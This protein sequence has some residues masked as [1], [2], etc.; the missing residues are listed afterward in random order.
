MLPATAKELERRTFPIGRMTMAEKLL[1]FSSDKPSVTP[2]EIVESALDLVLVNDV[3][4]PLAIDQFRKIGVGRVYDPSRIALV[5][6][7]Y[8]P[9]KDIKSAEQCKALRNFAREL[10]IDN[11]WEI[12]RCGIE[13]VLLPES[14]LVQ[15]GMVIVGADSHTCTYG[16][17]GAFATGIGSTEAADAMATAVAPFMHIL[18]FL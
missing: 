13:H 7:H 5:T 17:F 18:L 3:T 15:P 2:G 14:G 10:S 9:N 11:Y 1:A 8:A 16:A 12:G 6:D 4:G